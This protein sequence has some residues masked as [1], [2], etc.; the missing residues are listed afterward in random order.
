MLGFLWDFLGNEREYTDPETDVT[1]E[2]DSYGKIKPALITGIA[3]E[4][5]GGKGLG[6]AAKGVTIGGR[7]FQIPTKIWNKMSPVEQWVANQKFLDRMILRRDNIRL[8]TPFNQ[9]KPGSFFQKGLNY[10]FNKD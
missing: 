9:V 8:A 2:V 3:G 10:L 4:W 7:T 6:N 5:I 1:Y